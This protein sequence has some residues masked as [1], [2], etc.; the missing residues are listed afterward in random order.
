MFERGEPTMHVN[1]GTSIG[2]LCPDVLMNVSTLE[3]SLFHRMTHCD[4]NVLSRQSCLFTRFTYLCE[5]LLFL[6]RDLNPVKRE[7]CH[8][9]KFA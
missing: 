6:Q 1:K 4:A 9:A 5:N 3:A 8:K 2:N 7:L